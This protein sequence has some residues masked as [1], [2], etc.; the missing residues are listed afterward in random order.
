VEF[1]HLN[2][3]DRLVYQRTG[4][5]IQRRPLRDV[6]KKHQSVIRMIRFN[7]QTL[8]YTLVDSALRCRFDGGCAVSQ[9]DTSWKKSG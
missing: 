7:A 4:F 2:Y 6:G 8:R 1:K 3:E 9:K 5:W